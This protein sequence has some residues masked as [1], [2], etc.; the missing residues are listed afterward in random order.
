MPDTTPDPGFRPGLMAGP[1]N[2]LVC[3]FDRAICL[4]LRSCVQAFLVQ[5]ARELCWSKPLAKARSPLGRNALPDP[6][7][8]SFDVPRLAMIGGYS[9]SIVYR[10]IKALTKMNILVPA[11][12]LNLFINKD[13]RTWTK[14]DGSPLLSIDQ[15]EFVKSEVVL[16]GYRL[17]LGPSDAH[18]LVTQTS[19]VHPNAT[20]TS[21]ADV[22][23]V[24]QMSQ[25]DANVTRPPNGAGAPS[26]GRSGNSSSSSPVIEEKTP[27]PPTGGTTTEKPLASTP[28]EAEQSAQAV[29]KLMFQATGDRPLAEVAAKHVRMLCCQYRAADVLAS[30]MARWRE[31][32]PPA[33]WANAVATNLAN[34]ARAT[35]QADVDAAP[36]PRRAAPA[37]SPRT[38]EQDEFLRRMK[39][40]GV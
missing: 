29:G 40:A 24:T 17:P 25:S 30:Y 28:E 20:G 9:P 15:V 18:P 38:P 35:A 6:E 33:K 5:Q 3:D 1:V 11:D 32:I 8:F 21:D 4:A 10:N 39:E 16:G 23:E 7:P 26:G 13:Y 2:V 14:E 12:R 27:R 36:K 37:P 19:Q 31:E 22:T 34:R